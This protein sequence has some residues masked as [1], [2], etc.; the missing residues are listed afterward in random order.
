MLLNLKNT[1]TDRHSVNNCMDDLLEQ[2]KMEIARVTID[3]FNEIIK[4]YSFNKF[5]V[6]CAGRSK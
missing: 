2:W 5:I 3:G 6:S 4:K 1:M